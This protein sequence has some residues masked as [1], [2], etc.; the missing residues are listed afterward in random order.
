M[1]R[2]EAFILPE[3]VYA[4]VWLTPLWPI[5]RIDALPLTAVAGSDPVQS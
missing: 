5:R 2:G 3:I 1:L 4:H